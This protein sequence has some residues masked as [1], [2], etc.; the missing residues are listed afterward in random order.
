M[1]KRTQVVI[2][3]KSII[4]VAK[5]NLGIDRINPIASITMKSFMCSGLC[6][7]NFEE[8]RIVLKGF[9]R[10]TYSVHSMNEFN[11]CIS[12]QGIINTKDSWRRA[13]DFNE[14]KSV[15]V[16]FTKKNSNPPTREIA[17]TIETNATINPIANPPVSSGR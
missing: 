16:R 13:N 6:W 9:F 15:K 4:L 1:P 5:N 2:F 11:W 3:R 12:Q 17:L 8:L 14:R 7:K 10:L